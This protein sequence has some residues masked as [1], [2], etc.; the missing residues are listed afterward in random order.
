MNAIHQPR[1]ALYQPYPHTLGGLQAIVL[2]LG[3]GLGKEGWEPLIICPEEGK[4]AEVARRADLPVLISGP[5]PSWQVYGRGDKTLSYLFSPRRAWDLAAYWVRLARELRQREI[6]A[7]H[8]NDYRAVMLAAPAARLAG[9]PVIWHMHGYIPSRLANLAA[10]ALAHRVAAVSR[11]M[12]EYGHWPA[13]LA[14]KFCVIHN[15]LADSPPPPAASASAAPVI[16]AVGT[17]HPRKGY[18]TLIRAFGGISAQ[19]P[20]AECHILGAEF[21]DGAYARELRE[22]AVRCGVAEKVRF[23]GF[24][25]SVPA[26]MARCA[27]LAI[28]SRVE[29]FGMV[30]LEAMAAGKPVV[31][32]RTGGLQDIIV[33]GETGFLIENE[34]ANATGN[35]LASL[36]SDPARAEAMGSAGRQRVGREFTSSRML[37][38]FSRLY[39]AL[40]QTAQITFVEAPSSP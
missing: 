2:Q 27:V 14:R 33:E 6:A 12:L 19:F 31:A 5:G 39:R 32:A 21:G 3:R 16:L 1:I 34:D 7:L 18:E 8:C 10:A 38:A 17:L 25:D 37:G 28:P 11:G 36:L 22:L 40:T 9:I 15:G 4:F 13:F 24:C 20:E 30:A 23:R 35:R 29:A 26:E